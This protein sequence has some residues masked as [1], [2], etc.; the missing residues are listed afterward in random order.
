MII[1]ISRKLNMYS[2]NETC[3]LN[4][5]FHGKCLV[6]ILHR[7]HH[8]I[9]GINMQL[10]DDW[11]WMTYVV[12]IQSSRGSSTGTYQKTPIF[13]N[14]IWVFFGP[15]AAWIGFYYMLYSSLEDTCTLYIVF[16]IILI[17]KKN[18]SESFIQVLHPMPLYLISAFFFFK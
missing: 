14:W 18:M 16:Q 13:K 17:I 7:S 1:K 9:W 4:Q 5:T 12:I 10:D 11:T 6:Y 2:W 3:L 15:F 8:I